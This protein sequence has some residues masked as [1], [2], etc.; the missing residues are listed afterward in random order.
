MDKPVHNSGALGPVDNLCVTC[1]LPVDNLG[2]GACGF[3]GKL[4][5]GTQVYKRVI[6]LYIKLTNVNRS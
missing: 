1:V 6:L 3:F 4:E 5:V 2:A